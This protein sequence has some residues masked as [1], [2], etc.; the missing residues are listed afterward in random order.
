MTILVSIGYYQ[1]TDKIGIIK[2]LNGL[3]GK[4]LRCTF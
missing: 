1:I 3:I 2:L 4:D